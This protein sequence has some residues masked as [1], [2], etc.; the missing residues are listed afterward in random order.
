MGQN[1]C[2]QQFYFALIRIPSDRYYLQSESRSLSQV[3]TVHV[4]VIYLLGNCSINFVAVFLSGSDLFQSSIR[5]GRFHGINHDVPKIS[6]LWDSHTSVPGSPYFN[7][8]TCG[9]RSHLFWVFGKCVARYW[10]SAACISVKSKR[11]VSVTSLSRKRPDEIW[12]SFTKRQFCSIAATKIIGPMEIH[13]KF[14]KLLDF[15]ARILLY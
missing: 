15:W 3:K 13:V 5:N 8:P 12:C 1:I 6:W 2:V 4:N 10:A 11:S 9:A 7:H 14:Q